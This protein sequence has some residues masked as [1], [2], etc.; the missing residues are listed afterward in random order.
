[1]LWK[2]WLK[3]TVLAVVICL[4][5]RTVWLAGEREWHR[6]HGER[7]FVAAVAETDAA[8]PNWRWE[9]LNAARRRIP[10][11]ENA[12]VVISQIQALTTGDRQKQW[13]ELASADKPELPPNIRLPAQLRRQAA[14]NL[15]VS[16][17][18]LRLARTLKDRPAGFR[19]YTLAQNPLDTL[20]PEVQFTRHV[21]YL[22]RWAAWVAV[23]DGDYTHVAD[24]LVAALNTSR[25]LGDEPLLISQFVRIAT[26]AV[27]LRT[28]ERVLAQTD[29]PDALAALRL[30]TLQESLERDLADPLFLYGIR[31]ERAMF[32]VLTQRLGDGTLGLAAIGG[33]KDD[34]HSISGRLGW[35]LYGGRL[36]ADRAFCLRWFNAAVA[37]AEKPIHEQP[38]LL[39]ELPP[40]TR[41]QNILVLFLPAVDKVAFAHWR[42]VAEGRCA[43]VGIACERFRLKNG[44]WPETLGELCPVFLHAVLLDP[45]DGEPLRYQKLEDGIVIHS[46]ARIPVTH[47]KPLPHPGLPEGIEIGFRLWNP[48]ARRQP[49]PPE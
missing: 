10:D 47:G 15:A 24:D 18:A 30:P 19:E 2:K 14:D 9:A 1:M 48:E 49:A 42:S 45:F 25:S 40:V 22:L 23:E 3:R 29:Q 17:E 21:C 41:G 16:Q 20:L 36:P 31:G 33:S 26:R 12:A 27:M 11:S 38:A 4:V 13:D 8:D 39:D 5:I 44:R 6:A 43:V 35:W 7:E 34:D 28:T 46:V 37:M 32:D